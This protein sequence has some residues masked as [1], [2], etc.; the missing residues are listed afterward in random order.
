V[1]SRVSPV[2]GASS[3]A[4]VASDWTVESFTLV[5][6]QTDYTLSYA[7]DNDGAQALVQWGM[8]IFPPA[9]YAILSDRI[10][11]TETPTNDDVA[12]GQPLVVR[13]RRA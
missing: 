10:R 6:G 12:K 7:A 5:A 9:D 13:Y 2:I 8:T 1:P 3:S 4:A 11:L